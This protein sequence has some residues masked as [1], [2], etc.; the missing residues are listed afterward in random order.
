MIIKLKDFN[1]GDMLKRLTLDEI[2]GASETLCQMFEDALDMGISGAECVEA[3]KPLLR[4]LS[5]S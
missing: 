4:I 1:D 2:T 5:R 3:S